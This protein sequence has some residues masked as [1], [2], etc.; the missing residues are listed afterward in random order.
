M[1]ALLEM[2]KTRAEALT[3]ALR[4]SREGA[5]AEVTIDYHLNVLP[6]RD[7]EEL[8]P[9]CWLFPGPGSVGKQQE[10][11]VVVMFCFKEEDRATALVKLDQLVAALP[12]LSH[13]GGW[14]PWSQKTFAD[15]FGEGD[16]GVQPHPLYYY[17]IV[18]GFHSNATLQYTPYRP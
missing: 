13:P 4:F 2:V 1:K 10:R 6:A 17:K 9:F 18:L 16:A 5:A 15:S 7:M 12:L 11:H 14:S 3:A 8:A